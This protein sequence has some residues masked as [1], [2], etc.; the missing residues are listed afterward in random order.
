MP[1]FYPGTRHPKL[2]IVSPYSPICLFLALC[3]CSCLPLKVNVV[4]PHPQP[5]PDTTVCAVLYLDDRPPM[6]G[7]SVGYLTYTSNGHNGQ[8]ASLTVEILKSAARR[9][10]ANLVKITGYTPYSQRRYS[11]E[12]INATLYKVNDIQ[13]YEKVIAWN[14]HRRLTFADFKGRWGSAASSAIHSYSQYSIFDH[15]ARFNCLASWIDSSS[16][17]GTRLLI[18]EQGNFD[19]AECYTRQI[20]TVLDRR[21]RFRMPWLTLKLVKQVKAAYDAKRKEYDSV[22]DHGLDDARQSEWTK[23]IAAALAGN[24]DTSSLF[25]SGPL[26]TQKASLA[27]PLTPPPDKALVYI[28]RPKRF[29]SS[30][31]QRMLFNVFFIYPCPYFLFFNADKYEVDYAPEMATGHIPAHQYRCLLLDPGDRTF[32]PWAYLGNWTHDSPE[33]DLLLAPGKTYYLRLDMPSRWFAFHARPRLVLISDEAG[34]RL[35]KKCRQA[36]PKEDDDPPPMYTNGIFG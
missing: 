25:M 33:L 6:N 14:G 1:P 5:L 23:K 15:E 21:H 20:L 35:L 32:L 19:L 11:H 22:T 30:M 34:R 8:D 2:A 13:A 28:I 26:V 17:N 18:H 16:G 9:A 24:T 27:G 29:T 4:T 12:D 31:P 7:D 3:A 10:G 36:R